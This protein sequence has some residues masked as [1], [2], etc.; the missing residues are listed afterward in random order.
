MKKASAQSSRKRSVREKPFHDETIENTSTK[1]SRK[2]SVREEPFKDETMSQFIESRFKTPGFNAEAFGF[3]SVNEFG[4]YALPNSTKIGHA[5]IHQDESAGLVAEQYALPD[6]EENI[7]V[8]QLKDIQKIQ[9]GS[10][11]FYSAYS[12]DSP[13][14][15]FIG[16]RRH[17]QIDA[18]GK[19][20]EIVYFSEHEDFLE[21]DDK[22]G[23]S[24]YQ[25][26]KELNVY[27]KG[28]EEIQLDA[29]SIKLRDSSSSRGVTQNKV[30]AR[31][32]N[33]WSARDEYERFFNHHQDRMSPELQQIF[34]RAFNANI[35]DHAQ[36]QY[37]PEWL[38]R[39]GFS[40]MH[41]E[42]NP[43]TRDNLGAGPKWTNT[44][45]MVLERLAKWI[46]L[47]FEKDS[48]VK[49]KSLFEMLTHSEIVAKI[50]YEVSIECRG[51]FTR[52]VQELY[53]IQEN[54]LFHKTSDLAQIVGI[55]Q[56][57]I[58]GVE[59]IATNSISLIEEPYE[60]S[61]WRVIPEQVP[62]KI[63]QRTDH[64]VLTII[65]LETTGLD[66]KDDKIIEIGAI[67][68]DFNLEDG[69]VGLRSQYT[70][71]QD[72]CAPLSE[73]IIKITGLTDDDLQGKSIDWRKVND[74]LDQS[75]YI[76]CHNSSFD[77]KF[78]ESATPAFVQNKIQ[79][80]L[81]GCTLNGINWKKRGFVSAKL[82][83]LNARLKFTYPAHRALNDCWATINLL[84]NVP[85]ALNELIADIQQDKTL[86][87]VEDITFKQSS[88]LKAQGFAREKKGE[89][90]YWYKY[91]NSSQLETTLS[92]IE[93]QIYQEEGSRDRL[94]LIENI[95]ARDR[96]SI[97]VP[98]LNHAISSSSKIEE[99]S[100]MKCGIG[101]R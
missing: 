94:T 101:Y 11:C 99:E 22:D 20:S 19:E 43:Q 27:E 48:T 93:R 29:Y 26:L 85:S 84:Q 90:S 52:L 63:T 72:P 31:D 62:Q 33:S 30:M 64:Q 5:V 59:P 100:S 95:S 71:V 61:R 79:N 46:S 44:D 68:V 12:T 75:D 91:E 37:R 65:D 98:T 92:W 45:M 42:L 88:D 74:I 16:R 86:I 73:E 8:C 39:N 58:L 13:S 53:P 18:E 21:P 87:Y 6:L 78:L 24:L 56:A 38:H 2:R 54:P 97:R 34:Q 10:F 15:K 28:G 32:G 66:F 49:I 70:A 17:Q 81:F 7:K 55:T 9:R 96:Y 50:K 40:L 69:I 83:D 82:V 14:Q 25:E 80:M 41:H 57:Q 4:R 60:P 76:V 51:F 67:S 89:Q 3:L 23:P 35:Y 47:M 77:R 36:S 1:R